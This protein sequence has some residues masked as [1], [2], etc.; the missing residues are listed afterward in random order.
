MAPL[1]P[2]REKSLLYYLSK[3]NLFKNLN[4]AEQKILMEHFHE[5]HYQNDE[6][7]FSQNEMGVGMYF[8]YSGNVLIYLKNEMGTQIGNSNGNPNGNPNG[9]SN[10]NQNQM[11]EKINP[12]MGNDD[13]LEILAEL[14]AGDHFG[15]L[16]LV[17]DHSLRDTYAKAKGDCVLM[18]IFKPDLEQLIKNFPAVGAKF[19]LSLSHI[20]GRRLV[21][22]GQ[23][24]LSQNHFS[25]SS[26][27]THGDLNE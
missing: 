4:F 16:S 8:I 27:D 26:G 11:E 7:I 18:A 23:N 9:N 14:K 15:E 12:A 20:L 13:S 10:R 25:E 1:N 21:S 17:I 5:R 22:I 24:Q 3:Q 2:N 6:I 19:I